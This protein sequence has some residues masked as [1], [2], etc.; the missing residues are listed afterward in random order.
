MSLTI[1]KPLP[2][3]PGLYSRGHSQKY[4]I[5][6][7]YLPLRGLVCRGSRPDRH[8]RNGIGARIYKLDIGQK[9]HINKVLITMFTCVLANY[10][11]VN[12]TFSSHRLLLFSGL[13]GGGGSFILI[14]FVTSV[15]VFFST[16][17]LII[18]HMLSNL[19]TCHCGRN[20]VAGDLCVFLT[21]LTLLAYFLLA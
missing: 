12:S 11:L 2:T 15:G 7:Y 10:S 9:S 17:I 19:A 8:W 1:T 13:L 21:Q 14:G 5:A 3:C 6:S 4:R 16:I 18:A 20:L